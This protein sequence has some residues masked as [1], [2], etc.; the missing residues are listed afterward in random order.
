MPPI[1]QDDSAVNLHGRG[2]A[3]YRNPRRWIVER[4]YERMLKHP[5]PEI[6]DTGVVVA[7]MDRIP[8]VVADNVAEYFYAEKV[9][10]WN[11]MRDLPNLA[12]PFENFFVE[13]ILRDPRGGGA[14]V[15]A[16]LWVVSVDLSDTVKCAELKATFCDAQSDAELGMKEHI[17]RVEAAGARWHIMSH[18]FAAVGGAPSDIKHICIGFQ[19]VMP[20]GS[21]ALSGTGENGA[22]LI[23]PSETLAGLVGIQSPLSLAVCFMHCQNVRRVENLPSSKTVKRLVNA[24]Q[25][26]VRFTTLVIDPMKEVLRREGHSEEVG[27]A[28]ALHI[29]RGHFAHYTEERKLFG[30]YAKTVWVRQHRR[31]TLEKGAVVKKYVV[32][33]PMSS[34]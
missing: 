33:S 25:P 16:A 32:A 4:L 21:F 20:D 24:G 19:G 26:V 3:C 22:L 2:S 9:D 31:G 5:F 11:P 6:E 8:V 30:K 17:N 12:P 34:P 29:C 1:V 27:L 15:Q 14:V 28:K 13:A 23:A 10:N 18:L 7:L